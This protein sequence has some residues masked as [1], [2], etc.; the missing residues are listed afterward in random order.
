MFP[1]AWRRMAVFS[2]RVLSY[3]GNRTRM[4]GLG[5]SAHGCAF[6][7]TR[8]LLKTFPHPVRKPPSK[9]PAPGTNTRRP[10][11]LVVTPGKMSKPS[12][13]IPKKAKSVK[14]RSDKISRTISKLSMG[15]K[16]YVRIRAY[17]KSGKKTYYGNWSRKS[18]VIES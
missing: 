16:Y 14:I 8:P 6:M 2:C 4:C 17:H 15:K 10:L 11:Q 12:V 9:A 5:M 3:R 7:P 18:I 13:Y 1:A